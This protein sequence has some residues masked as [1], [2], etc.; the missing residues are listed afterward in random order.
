MEPLELLT[1][2]I[3][4]RRR[5]N[6]W[7]QSPMVG[8]PGVRAAAIAD[9]AQGSDITDAAPDTR[10]RA[11]RGEVAAQPDDAGESP[12]VQA[13]AA[14]T[15]GAKSPFMTAAGSNATEAPVRQTQGQVQYRKECG[16]N[17]CRMVPVFEGQQGGALPPGVTVGP[18]ETFVE[19]SLREVA[20]PLSAA[21]PAAT[22]TAQPATVAPQQPSQQTQQQPAA[23]PAPASADQASRN[24]AMQQHPA[25]ARAIELLDEAGVV[26]QT[27]QQSL[28]LLNKALVHLKIGDRAMKQQVL[29]DLREQE[30]Q[31]TDIAKSMGEQRMGLARDEMASSEKRTAMQSAAQVYAADQ[32]RIAAETDADARKYDADSRKGAAQIAADAQT[33]ESRLR[34]GYPDMDALEKIQKGSGSPSQKAKTYVA[35]YSRMVTGGG[36]TEQQGKELYEQKFGEITAKDSSDTVAAVML[37]RTGTNKELADSAPELMT[38]W[39]ADLYDRYHDASTPQ[40]RAAKMRAELRP[41]YQY[42]LMQYHLQA[43]ASEEESRALGI[44]DADQWMN[45]AIRAVQTMK[46][47]GFAPRTVLPAPSA[48]A[49]PQQPAPQQPPA[50]TQSPPIP[51]PRTG[52]P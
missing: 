18:G 25:Y 13:V 33:A 30:K 26:G 31:L 7:G 32:Q 6:P 45:A 48:T 11:R 51:I 29:S 12:V 1:A 27:R 17:G 35:V 38:R 34:A 49:A 22:A 4:Q 36:M 10:L 8:D 50:Q 44:K 15:Q 46:Q 9:A 14:T 37:A 42:R 43:G 2:R 3:R 23:A 21:T 39:Q 40:E 41:A 47:A 28:I 5:Y 20:R 19:G 52:R 24:A 16:P